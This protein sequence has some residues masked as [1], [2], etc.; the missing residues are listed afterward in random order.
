MTAE[1]L[2]GLSDRP[3]ETCG[4]KGWYVNHDDDDEID[5]RDMCDYDNDEVVKISCAYVCVYE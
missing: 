5:G 4:E 1:C 2:T 3:N